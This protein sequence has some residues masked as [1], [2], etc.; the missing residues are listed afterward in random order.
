MK[1]LNIDIETFSS[2]NL[3]KSGVYKYAESEDFE[4]L[5]FSYSVDDAKTEIIDLAQGEEIPKEIIEALKDN[6]IIKWAFNANFERI[7]ISRYLGEKYLNP[8]SWRC[9]MIWSAYLGLPL[10]LEG[11]GKILGLDKQKLSEGK[12]LIKYF[13]IPCLPTKTNGGRVR[14][15]PYQ[16]KDK[17]ELFKN[18]NIRDVETELEIQ[19]KLSKFPVPEFVWEE[20]QLDQAINDRGIKVDMD[21]VVQAIEFDS[22][23]RNQLMIEMQQIT[24]L[25][26]PNSVQQLKGWLENQGVNTES[27]GKEY[28][29][30][31][32][33]N[34]N[35]EVASAL[36]IRLKLAKSSIK[37]Y[38]AMVDVAGFDKRCRGMFQFMGANRTGRFSGR[39]IQ[40]QNL[41]RNYLSELDI[42]RAIIRS[43][44]TDTMTMLY[45]DVP[46][47]LSQLI[48]TAFIPKE[49]NKFFVADFS[50]IEAR[51]IA[52]LAGERWRKELFQNGGDIY[53]MSA[54]QMF[55]VPVVKHGVNG[56]LRQKGKIAELAC[57]YGGSVGALKAMGALSMGLEEDELQPLVT[58]WR[59]SNP[60]IVAL[61]WEVDKAVK[62]CIKKRILTKSH[63]IQFI[64][65][66]GMLRITLPSGRQLTYVKPKIGM[67]LFGGESVTYEGVGATKKWERIE[68]YGPKFVENIVQAIARD[69]LVVAMQRLSKKY[70][71]VAH[72]HDEVIIEAPMNTLL[73]EICQEMSLIP[74]WANGLILNADGYVCDF[75]KK[76]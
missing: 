1:R 52:W 33:K 9:T 46:D 25:E 3:V 37:K 50:A 36:S 14:N 40:L 44:D 17:W 35:G 70:D 19:Q 74:S 43:G 27:L 64:Y 68:S 18:Y 24:N 69:L 26:N 21:F 22:V 7:C 61:W 8:V 39:N 54:S 34:T 53:C 32:V 73:E 63:G 49:G 76:D 45:D 51:V 4:I 31:L 2:V 57:G 10:S 15:F 65:Q 20:Y 11:V 30:E 42:V 72:V 67:N 47:V 16:A 62:E 23:I 29:K 55:G 41:P 38:Q 13:C 59:E 28:V 56:E 71:I 48:R 5:L 66:S 12:E 6:T 60:N 75:Y 58:A